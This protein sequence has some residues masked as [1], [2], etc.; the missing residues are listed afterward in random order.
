M[1]AG[2]KRETKNTNADHNEA[3]LDFCFFLVMVIR[4][5]LWANKK[6]V[7]RGFTIVSHLI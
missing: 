7:K 5:W 1:D 6:L 4:C 3:R 2:E